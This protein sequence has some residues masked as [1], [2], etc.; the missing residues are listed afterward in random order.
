G[1]LRSSCSS[2][3]TRVTRWRST[4]RP[5][6]ICWPPTRRPSAGT[7]DPA[8]QKA[9]VPRWP[10]QRDDRLGR[11]ETRCGTATFRRSRSCIGRAMRRDTLGSAPTTAGPLHCRLCGSERMLS[12]LDLGATPPSEKFLTIHELDLPESTLPLHLRLCED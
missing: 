5:T 9:S 10:A 7:V 1:P 12:I 3:R 2:S 11:V 8:K 4:R 6:P